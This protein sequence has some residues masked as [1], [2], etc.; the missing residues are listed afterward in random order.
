MTYQD[1]NLLKPDDPVRSRDLDDVA[2]RSNLNDPPEI[3]RVAKSSYAG[4]T[5][6]LLAGIVVV[7][8]VIAFLFGYSGQSSQTAGVSLPPTTSAPPLPAQASRTAV[9]PPE[10]T[11]QASPATPAP[12][13]PPAATPPAPSGSAQ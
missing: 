13:T 4:G 2:R 10:T 11:G 3:P 9:T 6:G 8:L 12:A 1:P 5:I 7:I